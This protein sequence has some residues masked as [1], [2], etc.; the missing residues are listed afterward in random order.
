MRYFAFCLLLC[1][2]PFCFGQNQ[3]F[4]F[5]FVSDTHIG[6][7]TGA[8]D[9]MRTVKD[10]NA[11][12]SLDFVVV[13]GDITEFGSDDELTLA[14]AIL[15]SLQKPWHVIPGN[16]DSNWSE[17]GSNSFKTIFGAESFYFLHKGYAFLGTA[18]GPNMRM[19]PGQVPREHLVWLDST[20]SKLPDPKMPVIYLNHY[21][22][23]S[24]LNNWYDAL[25]RLKKNNIQLILCGHGHSNK[26]FDFEKI[27]GVMGRS[28]L[29]AKDEI[30]GYNIVT[31]GEGKASFEIKKPFSDSLKPWNEVALTDHQFSKRTEKFHRPSYAVNDQFRNVK[32]VWSYQDDSDIGSGVTMHD[33]VI[34]CSDTKGVLFALNKKGKKLWEYKTEGKIYSTPA[35]SGSSVVITSSDKNI[36]CVDIKTGQLKWKFSAGKPIVANPVIA[37]GKVFSGGSDGHFRAMNLETGQLIWDFRDVK[38]FVV[39]KPLIYQGKIFFGCWANDFYALDLKTGAL[40]WKWNNGAANRMFSPAAVY[41]VASGN[42]VFIV[43][44]DRFMTALNATS[45]QVIW[46]KQIPTVRVRESIGLSSDSSLVFVKTMDGDIYG[47]STK[48]D[49]MALS[50][51]A[52]LKLPYEISPTA[53]VET[54]NILYVP[55]NSGMVC[56]IDRSS[57][58]T[59][60]KH[61]ISNGLISGITPISKREVLVTTMDGKVALL[62]TK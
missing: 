55:S 42:R 27:P 25:D 50:W 18:S 40:V 16:H 57:G 28:N 15:D 45:G 37:D 60:W 17:S 43:A 20:L 24:A 11:N 32:A 29:R 61:K 52:K 47:V 51:K 12:P 22:Q 39:T 58:E 6:G 10:I 59:I 33:K 26:A 3:N 9:L 41:P 19:G 38:G 31:I 49:S 54:S 23:D 34:L 7:S 35:A 8:E 21:P 62:R 1:I 46:R 14:K 53:L 56:A 2:A 13:T 30:G 5:A 36:Y 4:K 44:P 48:A